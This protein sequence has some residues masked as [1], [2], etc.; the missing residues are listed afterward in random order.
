[1]QLARHINPDLILLDIAMPG[2][3]GWE[4]AQ[5]IRRQGYR[6][7]V[8]MLSA[9]A[10][11][12]NPAIAD[13]LH[14]DYLTK[15][16]K[17]NSL[18][19]SLA[20]HLSLTWVHRQ[21]TLQKRIAVV[22]QTSP[23]HTLQAPLRDELLALAEIGHLTGLRERIVQARDNAHL[24]AGLAEDMQALLKVF[25]FQSVIRLLETTP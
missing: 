7:P 16:L 11:E 4:T 24:D 2:L 13:G 18:L 19:D 15:P 22:Q 20:R 12:N 1:M 9:N 23:V 14:N 8:V 5:H 3:T 21:N 6:G 10:R 25:D 17:L